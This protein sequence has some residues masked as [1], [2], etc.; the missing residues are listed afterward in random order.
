[1]FLDLSERKPNADR[2]EPENRIYDIQDA[3]NHLAGE[4]ISEMLASCINSQEISVQS[5]D[6][7]WTTEGVTVH[8]AGT[9]AVYKIWSEY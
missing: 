3:D 9:T 7:R 4:Q 6:V 2:A 1:V 5:L 8:N